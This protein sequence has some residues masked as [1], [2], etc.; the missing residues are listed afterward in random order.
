MYVASIDAGDIDSHFR[1]TAMTD[2]AALLPEADDEP[3]LVRRI[4]SGDRTAFEKVMR[5]YNRRLYRIA[6]SMLPDDSEAEDALQEAYLQIYKSIGA[7]KGDAALSTWMTRIVANECLGRL[8]RD[9]RRQNVVKFVSASTEVDVETL[10]SET[11]DPPDDAIGR[12]QMRALLERK[13][14]ELPESFR[15]VFVLRSVEE[16]SVEDTALCLNLPEATVRSRHFR[17]RSLLRE[18]LARDI[19]IAERDVFVFGGSHCDRIV[20]RVLERLPE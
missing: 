10:T 20:A 13:L 8:R 7:F 12:T 17:A 18:S 15:V 9:A 1:H 16:M 19:D 3:S 6:R 11:S 4:A 5:H 14:D 2:T